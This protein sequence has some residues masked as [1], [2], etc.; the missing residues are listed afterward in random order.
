[1]KKT[2]TIEYHVVM[3]IEFANEPFGDML[4]KSLKD[5]METVQPFIDRPETTILEQSWKCHGVM[6]TPE[7]GDVK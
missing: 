6:E 4:Q 1:M 2:F 3:Q 5:A 7:S